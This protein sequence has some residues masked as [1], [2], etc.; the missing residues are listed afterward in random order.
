MN[1]KPGSYSASVKAYLS[2]LTFSELGMNEKE[3]VKMPPAAQAAFLAALFTCCAKPRENGAEMTFSFPD[4]AEATEFLLITLCGVEA[5]AQKSRSG[6]RIRL[7]LDQEDAARVRSFSASP[8]RGFSASPENFLRAAFLS[9]GTVQDPAKGYHLSFSVRDGAAADL[10]S[11]LS[12]VIAPPKETRRQGKTVLYYKESSLIE[13]FLSAI[14][15][16]KFSLS[17]M[18]LKVEKSIRSNVNRRQNFDDANLRRAVDRSQK[19]LEA[20]R[21]LKTKKAYDALPEALKSAANLLAAYPEATL[22]ELCEHSEE[23]ITKSGLD[24]RFSRILILADERKRKN[25]SP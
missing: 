5:K 3:K 24:H 22:K 16:Q 11:A 18:N 9:C 23:P 7:I 15:A 13:D 2:R 17:V 20:I 14:G 19:V 21:F 6:A 8:E 25:G 4:L 1:E 10:R 12:C